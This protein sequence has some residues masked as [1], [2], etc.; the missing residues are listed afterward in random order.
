MVPINL[1]PLPHNPRIKSP[2]SG[3]ETTVDKH[4]HTTSF[5]DC[6]Y[7]LYKFYKK[8]GTLGDGK[9]TLL[10]LNSLAIGRGSLITWGFC[11][12]PAP[13]LWAKGSLH[14]SSAA[15]ENFR[16]VSSTCPLHSEIPPDPLSCE[17]AS[18]ASSRALPRQSSLRPRKAPGDQVETCYLVSEMLPTH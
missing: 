5:K 2:K 11:N 6:P 16:P 10:F 4:K 13:L 3:A 17:E 9:L 15:A 12:P 8:Q 14:T 18:W 7:N 1:P